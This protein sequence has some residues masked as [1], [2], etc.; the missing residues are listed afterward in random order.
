L[1]KCG[2]LAKLGNSWKNVLHL[3]TCGTVVKMRKL[4]KMRHTSKN[5][6]RLAKYATLKKIINLL[7]NA[8]HLEKCGTLG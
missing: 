5:A 4:G 2:K 7:Q 3:K 1:Q 6:P 8:S